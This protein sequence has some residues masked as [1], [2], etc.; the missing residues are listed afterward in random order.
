MHE[1]EGNAREVSKENTE[2]CIK[3]V[4]NMY[5]GARTLV[6]SSERLTR[7]QRE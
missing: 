3:T 5:E 4:Q 6:K 1:G 7:S 2:K